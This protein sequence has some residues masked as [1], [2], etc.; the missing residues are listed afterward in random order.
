MT[1]AHI[2]FTLD[3]RSSA[4]ATALEDGA[5]KLGGWGLR[6]DETDLEDESFASL[7][8][9]LIEG[10]RDWLKGPAPLLLDHDSSKVLGRV[11]HARHVPGQGVWVEAVV[12]PVPKW[13][14]LRPIYDAIR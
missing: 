7:G 10:L 8:G 9:K 11:T 6:Y 4:S 1:T 14:V 12:D 13:S 5:L 2:P 3:A